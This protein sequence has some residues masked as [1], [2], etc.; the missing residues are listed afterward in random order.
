MYNSG[1][2]A[3]KSIGT[4][5]VNALKKSIGNAKM[6][7]QKIG[8]CGFQITKKFWQRDLFFHDQF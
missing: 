7:V 6:N 8:A 3:K 1:A 2:Y 4:T 5:E